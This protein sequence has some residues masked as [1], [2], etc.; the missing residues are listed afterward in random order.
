M[1]KVCLSVVIHFSMGIG[2][3]GPA[4]LVLTDKAHGALFWLLSA[5]RHTNPLER[6][7]FHHCWGSWRSRHARD[8]RAHTG[9]SV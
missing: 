9:P 2:A 8:P 4:C 3:H 5:R 7:G 6:R 1:C